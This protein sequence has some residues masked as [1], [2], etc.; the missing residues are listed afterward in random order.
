MPLRLPGQSLEEEHRELLRE[1]GRTV[2]LDG[3]AI[4]H[5]SRVRVVAIPDAC[6]AESAPSPCR[7]SQRWRSCW[8]PLA[9]SAIAASAKGAAPWN[10]G[11][12]GRR[13]ISRGAARCGIFG[14]PRCDR[15][16]IQH[17]SRAH[18]P[19]RSLRRIETK[20]SVKPGGDA[21][22][23]F[24][25]EQLM[26]GLSSRTETRLR[27]HKPLR[28]GWPLSCTEAQEKTS[29]SGPSFCSPDGLSGSRNEPKAMLGAR[30]P[31]PCPSSYRTR[32]IP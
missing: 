5:A 1:Q 30:K 12:E 19:G 31:R 29:Q 9:R 17:R 13:P 28:D 7:W 23:H 26:A 2:D 16:W 11:R 6:V 10:S 15:R 24:E 4:R 14:V 18:R 32:R 20:T 21:E 22:I 8:P 27:R 25:G 3:S